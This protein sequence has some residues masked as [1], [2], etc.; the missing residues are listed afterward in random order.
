MSNSNDASQEHDNAGSGTTIAEQIERNQQKQITNF[1]KILDQILTKY[2]ICFGALLDRSEKRRAAEETLSQKTSKR[3]RTT[4][5]AQIRKSPHI[6]NT[7]IG[8]GESSHHESD[9][10]DG[11]TVTEM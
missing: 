7:L 9:D 2:M 6:Q 8:L 3:A 1:T 10:E 4:L 5:N 11:T